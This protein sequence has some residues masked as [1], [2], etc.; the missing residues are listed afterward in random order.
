MAVPGMPTGG[1]V[2]APAR[3]REP[4]ADVSTR[5]RVLNHVIADG[6]VGA[7]AL[8]ATLGLTPAGVRRHL[9]QLEGE[10]LIS[11]HRTALADGGRGRPARLFVATSRGQ[12]ELAAAYPDLAVQALRFLREAA[13]DA[14]VERFARARTAEF[15]R[16]T[17]GSVT[18]D[19]VEGRARQLAQVLAGEGYA[20]SVRPVPGGFALQL[21]QGHCPVQDVAAEFPQ[22][23]EAEA[24]AF[25]ELLGSH[26]Q[27]LAT[28]AGGGHACTT[29]VP[30]HPPGADAPSPRPAPDPRPAPGRAPTER[31]T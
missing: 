28:L 14:A 30:V 1:V 23:C 16:R 17:A 24:E 26:V 5:D 12:S 11:E 19:D 27:R 9:A 18:A 4:E 15:T 3:T 25:S 21:C 6:P 31:T 20:A 7:V 13:G 2:H 8:A 10:G 22:L 29:N